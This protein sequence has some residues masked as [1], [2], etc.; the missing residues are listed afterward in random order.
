MAY[1][2]AAQS[3]TGK[4]TLQII[5][6]AGNTTDLHTVS[7]NPTGGWQSWTSTTQSVELEKGYHKIRLLIQANDFNINWFDFTFLS[8]TDDQGMGIDINVFPN[9]SDGHFKM[10]A[11]LSDYKSAADFKILNGQGMV[12]REFKVKQMDQLPVVKTFDLTS[13]PDG[14]YFLSIEQDGKLSHFQTLVKLSD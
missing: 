10:L 8:D 9:P 13:F 7:F 11:N 2:T 4:V 5:D 3:N 14:L 6:E 1:R 12:V